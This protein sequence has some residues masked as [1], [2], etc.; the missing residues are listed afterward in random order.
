MPK[1]SEEYILNKKKMI[2]DAAYEL[3]LEKTV[4]TV[5]MQDIINRTGLSQG[6]IYRFYRDIDEVFADMLVAMRERVSIKAK[7]DEIFEREKELPAGEIT[8]QIFEM[9]AEFMTEELMGV[10]K[11]DFELSVLA[12]N[13]PERVEKILAG[14]ECAH[15]RIAAKA[16]CGP[17]PCRAGGSLSSLPSQA[18]HPGHHRPGEG[19]G[20]PGRAALRPGPGLPRSPHRRR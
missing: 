6:G 2:T 5:T 1:V 9:L 17:D 4:S 11:V 12:M 16:F 14:A 18:P 10:E 7:V 3:C 20:P 13:A 15:R 19:P 8:N